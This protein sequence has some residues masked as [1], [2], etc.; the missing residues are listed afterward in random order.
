MYKSDI[1]AA[2]ELSNKGDVFS[3]FHSCTKHSADITAA[4]E[5]W[6]RP[7]YDMYIQYV[8]NPPHYRLQTIYW[9]NGL[10]RLRFG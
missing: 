8:P 4:D 3:K 7:P 2:K 1:T 6:Q 9:G 5:L 10:C